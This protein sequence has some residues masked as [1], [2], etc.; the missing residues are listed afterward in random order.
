MLWV[1]TGASGHIG[2][3]LV[4]L[5]LQHGE[6][7]R[8]VVH[9]NTV[10]LEGMSPEK[11]FGDVCDVESL[12]KAFRNADVVVNLAGRISIARHAEREVNPVNVVGTGNVVEAARQC[13]VRRL[14][15][16]SS[17]HAIADL[18]AD[19]V[20]DEDS[21]LVSGDR[22]AAYD[23]SKAWGELTV[24][25]AIRDGFDAVVVA[26]T[27]VVGPY[28]FGPSHFGNVLLGMARRRI[29]VLVGGGF[30]WV[31]V[32]DVAEAAIRAG[33]ASSVSR[34]YMLSGHWHSVMDVS[35]MASRYTGIPAASLAAPRPL[36]RLC[37][38]ITET[39]CGLT[40]KQPLFTACAVDALAQHPRVSH[41]KASRELGYSPRPLEETLKD[42]YDWFRDNGYLPVSRNKVRT[43]N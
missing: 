25:E 16:F 29:P 9:R 37:G 17:I 18:P 39:M 22:V 34:K 12:E 24:M 15:H 31:D 8:A 20:T 14:V 28:D 1:V 7:V 26:P 13:S 4:R 33:T 3:N 40:G 19:E 11:V 35:R 42:T 32:R 23:S 5:L 38:S 21:P 10:A 41:D 30:D 36:A 43:Q 6:S 2:A 27:A